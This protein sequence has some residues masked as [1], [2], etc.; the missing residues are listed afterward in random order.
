MAHDERRPEELR[1][2][3]TTS[4]RNYVSADMCDGLKGLPDAISTT[5]PLATVQASST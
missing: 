5:W 4:K 2:R 1:E 3:N